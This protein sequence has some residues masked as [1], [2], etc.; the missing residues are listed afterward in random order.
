[1]VSGMDQG[2]H[3]IN[4]QIHNKRSKTVNVNSTFKN[5]MVKP[6]NMN[7]S[8]N[9]VTHGNNFYEPTRNFV[10][11]NYN[12]N[13]VPINN[14]NNVS[15]LNNYQNGM[16]YDQYFMN[17]SEYENGTYNIN[18]NNEH[19]Y[20]LQHQRN[21]LKCPNNTML[22]QSIIE[23]ILRNNKQTI[24]QKVN[25]N[26]NKS[27]T[28][29]LKSV[30][31]SYLIKPSPNQHNMY[32]NQ[33]NI[34]EN[35]IHNNAYNYPNLNNINDQEF[36]V[37]NLKLSKTVEEN[38]EQAI[39]NDDVQVKMEQSDYGN[40]RME[41]NYYGN[42]KMV[43]TKTESVGRKKKK[44][45]ID[46]NNIDETVTENTNFDIKEVK[47][48]GRKR[49]LRVDS[50]N[51]E[52][53]NGEYKNGECKNGE[54]KNEEN[55]NEENKNEES[56][57]GECKNEESKNEENN[58]ENKNEENK[59][60]E[61]KNE[62][63]KNEENKNE[64]INEGDD[65]IQF[66][67]KGNGDGADN[68]I[69]QTSLSYEENMKDIKNET[70]KILNSVEKNDIEKTTHEISLYCN[71]LKNEEINFKNNYEKIGI[72]NILSVFKNKLNK[73]KINNNSLNCYSEINVLVNNFL[74]VLRI[75][76]R[77]KKI[78][79]DIYSYNFN[80]INE[81]NIKNYFENQFSFIKCYKQNNELNEHINDKDN[82][83][84]K[85]Y[86]IKNE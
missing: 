29:F 26:M 80:I 25:E 4:N 64:E 1:M 9:S 40:A 66:I 77:H 85:N 82:K 39:Q 78:L 58:E 14:N 68:N 76:N 83:K 10:N 54:S 50:K 75:I 2:Y 65:D 57:N 30:S 23:K 62:E 71:K 53:E 46:P 24:D 51:D 32:N 52:N 44:K 6:Y 74:Y 45:N 49:K 47:K 21:Q 81:E 20:H 41:Q 7:M 70:V 73:I 63:N 36:E 72:N 55:K 33:F 59:N 35:V 42:A 11:N 38:Y 27:Y 13:N 37:Y 31:T 79:G 3:D 17:S 56:K 22:N 12:I 48:K 15:Q 18:N 84:T 61:N 67:D 43:Y 28:N 69:V 34:D 60:G 19:Y 5:E 86:E 8:Y 16:T